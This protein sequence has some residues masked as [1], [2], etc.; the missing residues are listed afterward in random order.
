M[1]RAVQIIVADD[2]RSVRTVIQ[3]ALTRQ[4][5]QVLA[6]SNAAAM[7][8]LVSSG[9]G[10][11][12]ITDVG[13]PDG[14]ALEML[15]RLQ[16]KRPDLQIIVMSARSNLLTAV[17][18]QQRDVFEYL[19]KP[20]ELRALLDV[21]ARA[22]AA[23]DREMS[24]SGGV[25]AS[26]PASLS[27]PLIGK[28]PVMQAS[29][30]QL[31]RFATQD[32]PVLIEAEAGSG[33]EEVART[34]HE[35]SPLADKPLELC[36]LARLKPEQQADRLFGP[37]GCFALAASGS[38]LITD[39][40]LLTPAVQMQMVQRL[41]AENQPAVRLLAGSGQPLQPLVEA[42]AFR[43]DLH[44]ALS[45]AVLRLPPL[46]DRLEDLPELS[47]WICE[48]LAAETGQRR[49]LEPQALAVLQSWH[50]PGNL[51]GLR[52]V[53]KRVFLQSDTGFISATDIEQALA[54]LRR[55][56]DPSGRSGGDSLGAAADYHIRR[57][58]QALGQDMP[59]PG[60]YDRVMQEVEKPL[61]SATLRKTG[62]NQIRAAEILGLNR[63]TLRKKMRSL[64]LSSKRADY[65]DS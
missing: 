16:E 60:L 30:K 38:L 25:R 63:N 1:G 3:H 23:P 20:F 15:P 39:I 26:L 33:T 8:D 55:Q 56:T 65:R 49:T 21:C 14:D 53:L 48:Q 32:I 61:L 31:A 62:G 45:V 50:W 12:L 58:F 6:A 35:M 52:F 17:Q 47:H 40:D 37:Q 10:R 2:D 28:S 29:F 42:G 9:R 54:D 41:E 22:I 64:N 36:Q 59:A 43:Q 46:R 51:E 27:G 19:P 34:L 24:S 5:Y 57:Y 13:F 4:G 11:L 44:F 7:W 18:A